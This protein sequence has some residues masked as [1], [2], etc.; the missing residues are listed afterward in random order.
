[1]NQSKTFHISSL[2][3]GFF[4]FGAFMC[5]LCFRWW[6][7]GWPK[8]GS[9]GR[10]LFQTLERKFMTA[11]AI[12][13]MFAVWHCFI[14]PVPF[15]RKSVRFCRAQVDCH[16]EQRWN[17]QSWKRYV[18]F[19]L[20]VR[21]AWAPIEN[22]D[23]ILSIEKQKRM[24]FMLLMRNFV[25]HVSFVFHRIET[26]WE[27]FFENDVVCVVWHLTFLT[28]VRCKSVRWWWVSPKWAETAVTSWCRWVS[29]KWTTFWPMPSW[30]AQVRSNSDFFSR[31]FCSS[32]TSRS[33]Q[34]P[35]RTLY[36]SR[37][38]CHERCEGKPHDWKSS[39]RGEL[40]GFEE[41][42]GIPISVFFVVKNLKLRYA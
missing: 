22:V 37:S 34:K 36:I 26:L 32:S 12:T 25:D 38:T 29:G 18:H 17:M 1:M 30:R 27:P 7:V 24:I 9:I 10:V 16:L 6:Y 42:K 15:S 11:D 28:F 35:S 14:A 39:Q 3:F 21:S 20:V 8:H 23:T 41:S 5:I 33:F 31:I 40:L 4:T 13:K 19:S 2:W